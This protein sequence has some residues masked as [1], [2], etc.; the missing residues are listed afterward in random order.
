MAATY[1]PIASIT[2]GASA[3][4]VTFSSIPQTY[5]DLV[6]VMS[7]ANNTSVQDGTELFSINSDTGT[8]YS[9]TELYGNGSS[10]ASIRRTGTAYIGLSFF[11][12]IDTTLGSTTNVTH[13]MNYSNATTYKTILNRA[14]NTSST[15]PGASLIASLWRST[16]AITSFS[17]RPGGSTNFKAGSTFNLYGI[18]GANA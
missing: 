18:L 5:T 2:L 16:A 10:A 8:N 1:T 3:A 7:P 4:S 13:F 17:I 11:T 9:F 12:T 15:Y 6:M 14:N